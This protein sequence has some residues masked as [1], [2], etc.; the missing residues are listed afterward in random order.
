ML[1]Q[2]VHQ[3]RYRYSQ[4]VSLELHE[5]RLRPR[6]DWSQ[7]LLDFAL[8]IEPEPAGIAHNIDAE[9]NAVARAWFAD[10]HSE[11]CIAMR[12]TVETLCTNPFEFL[13][14]PD[15][16]S[17]PAKYGAAEAAVLTPYRRPASDIA[18]AVRALGLELMD[19]TDGQVVPCLQALSKHIYETYTGEVRLAGPPLAAEETL[20]R[21]RGACRDLAVLFIEV[22]RSLGLA[23]RFVSGYQAGDPKQGERYMHAWAEVYLPGA[24]W[25]GW[26]PS[27]GLAVA[28]AHIAVATGGQAD[29]AQPLVGHFRGEGVRAVSDVSLQLEAM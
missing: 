1:F 9:G 8:D 27:A 4:P 19:Q 22:C 18:D 10:F 2:I 29:A 7:R 20:A 14:A 15:F 25:R 6:C 16:A 26:D 24:G 17:L 5:I 28:D 13:L 11:L 21:R 23:A 3:T 12:A